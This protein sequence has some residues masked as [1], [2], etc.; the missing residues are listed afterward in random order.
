MQRN[1]IIIEACRRARHTDNGS[2]TEKEREKE[3]NI[4]DKKHISIIVQYCNNAMT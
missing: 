3:Q 1:Q 2:E 4:A